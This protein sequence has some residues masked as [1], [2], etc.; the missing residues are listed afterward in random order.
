MYLT[1]FIFASV[2]VL[3]HVKNIANAQQIEN[4]K[5]ND[6]NLI[7]MSLHELRE[8]FRMYY[9]KN[10]KTIFIIFNDGE[11]FKI[12]NVENANEFIK[13]NFLDFRGFYDFAETLAKFDGINRYQK[14]VALH[15]SENEV[16]DNETLKLHLSDCDN[17]DY[18]INENDPDMNVNRVLCCDCAA[19]LT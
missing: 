5:F 16:F 1:I 14:L 15:E 10:L 2:N 3:T 4:L 9:D 11:T 18:P 6:D 19:K 13:T 7:C 8:D 17:C 12:E